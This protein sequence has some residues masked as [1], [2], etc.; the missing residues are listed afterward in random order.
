M[1][2]QQLHE[3]R[4]VGELDDGVTDLVVE[5]GIG[6]DAAGVHS[7]ATQ[8]G[9]LVGGVAG[10][11][12]ELT[13]RKLMCLARLVPRGMSFIS[14]PE[15]IVG[16]SERTVG[17]EYRRML[18]NSQHFSD[19]FDLRMIPTV[20]VSGVAWGARPIVLSLPLINA[21]SVHLQKSIYNRT[22]S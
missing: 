13:L 19:E 9:R 21:I 18:E 1:F 15:S 2:V 17:R 4:G 11:E 12:L 5:S 6:G 3:F 10:L 22:R 7:R 16:G 8:C 20:S 14:Y